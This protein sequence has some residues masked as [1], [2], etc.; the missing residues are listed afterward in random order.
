[1]QSNRQV[2]C[3]TRRQFVAVGAMG[4]AAVVIGCTT[5]RQGDW[6][7]LSEEQ[8]GTLKAICDAIVPADEFL[9]AS[10]AG[11][12]TFIDRQLN[13]HFRRYR[14]TYTNGLEQTN[15]LS[16][17]RFGRDLAAL[18]AGQQV[19]ITGAIEQ[20]NRD[21]FNLVRDHTLAGY[22]GSPRH[23]GN[24][25]AVSWRMLGLAAPPLRGQ[26]Q[27]DLRKGSAS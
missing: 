11:V 25:D 13:R 23:G 22:Y 20:Q 10:Q 21:F 12:L 16:R 7:F 26:A 15:A 24:R 4:G 6:E 18:S 27:Y 14:N 8:A 3:L 19:A 2:A 5:G 17:Q 1:L 9:S